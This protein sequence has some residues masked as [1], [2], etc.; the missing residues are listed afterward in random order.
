[1]N[2]LPSASFFAVAILM[3]IF[4]SPAPVLAQQGNPP[5][6]TSPREKA[7][8]REYAVKPD[9]SDIRYGPHERNVLDFWKAKSDAPAPVVVHIHGGGA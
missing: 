9:V 6:R 5:A 8:F 7:A 2:I 1:M 3:L 4:L